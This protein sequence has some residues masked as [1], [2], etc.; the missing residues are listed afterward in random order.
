MCYNNNKTNNGN[1]VPPEEKTNPQVIE[2]QSWSLVK[3]G[4]AFFVVT[5]GTYFV[6]AERY[7]KF[8]KFHKIQV[9]Q[10]AHRAL[11]IL[12]NMALHTKN[13]AN[14]WSHLKPGDI[15]SYKSSPAGH[16]FRASYTQTLQNMLP[17]YENLK[18]MNFVNYQK[19]SPNIKNADTVIREFYR[20]IV[21]LP[22]HVKKVDTHSVIQKAEYFKNRLPLHQ[23][24]LHGLMN[25]QYVDPKMMQNNP[26]YL[27]QMQHLMQSLNS[28]QALLI[29]LQM[30]LE[31]FVKDADFLSK[32]PSF[33]NALCNMKTAFPYLKDTMLKYGGEIFAKVR[34]FMPN[35]RPYLKHFA[36]IAG[37]C[38]TYAKAMLGG[39]AAVGAAKVAAIAGLITLAVCSVAYFANADFRQWI[40]EKFKFAGISISNFFSGIWKDFKSLFASK[41]VQ[42]HMALM[43][44]IKEIGYI[45]ERNIL[46][47]LSKEYGAACFSRKGDVD[48]NARFFHIDNRVKAETYCLQPHDSVV[49]APGYS[50]NGTFYSDVYYNKPPYWKAFIV[51]PNPISLEYDVYALEAHKSYLFLPANSSANQTIMLNYG[52]FKGKQEFVHKPVLLRPNMS[53]ADYERVFKAHPNMSL[54]E[55]IEDA[56]LMKTY[57]RFDRTEF[58]NP[59]KLPQIMVKPMDEGLYKLNTTEKKELIKHFMTKAQAPKVSDIKFITKDEISKKTQET[60][61]MDEIYMMLMSWQ[62]MIKKY[63]NMSVSFPNLD[64]KIQLEPLHGQLVPV[65]SKY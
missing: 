62:E 56:D 52:K 38:I 26:K 4:S 25:F 57:G 60:Q 30:H 18:N 22:E 37:G 32:N 36:L 54:Q 2:R 46:D 61:K 65:D 11:K 21:D 34:Q 23:M 39:I 51:R 27:A 17:H 42:N 45:S 63:K 14:N 47:A 35:L 8:Y 1:G 7:S 55:I 24:N 29:D 15:L 44:D 10:D 49:I 19:M 41:D 64:N 3:K 48:N 53:M 20:L 13:F 6:A 59:N 12:D 50:R 16:A 31:K 58:I 9:A 5:T 43:P 33:R 40:N 28:S